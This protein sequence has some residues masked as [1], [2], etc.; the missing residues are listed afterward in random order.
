MSAR[1]ADTLNPPGW[2]YNPA[3]WSQR[4]PI[5]VLALGGVGIATYLAL[6]QYRVID[7]IWDPFF[8]TSGEPGKNSSEFILTSDLSFPLTKIHPALRISDAALGAFAYLLDAVTGIVGGRGRWRTMPWIVI[9]FAILV[10]PLGLVSVFLTVA[11]PV[12]YGQ[13]CTL[14]LASAVV[15]LLMIGPAMDEALAS[16]QFMRRAHDTPGVPFWKTFWGV[17]NWNRFPQESK[18]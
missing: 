14:C 13:W 7:G 6:Y 3:T 10:G 2:D 4:I 16:C 17:G 12:F 1:A 11:Q 5:V 15:S 18:P 8:A 9:L